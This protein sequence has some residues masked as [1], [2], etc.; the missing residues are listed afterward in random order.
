MAFDE[1]KANGISK[2]LAADALERCGEAFGED[3]AGAVA[4]C[5]LFVAIKHIASTHRGHCIQ[6]TEFAAA[7]AML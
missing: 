1:T 5:A 2:D 7:N 6:V 3:E 4:I